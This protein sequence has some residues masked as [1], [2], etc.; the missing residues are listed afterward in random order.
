MGMAA[1]AASAIWH[2]LNCHVARIETGQ[3]GAVAVSGTADIVRALGG[4]RLVPA[5]SPGQLRALVRAGLPYAALS[6]VITGFR[7]GAAE[8]GTALRIPER[9]LARRRK[10]KRLS[11]EES[12]RLVRLARIAAL[13]EETLGGRDRAA[14]WLTAENRALGGRTPI[15][16]LDTDLGAEEVEA[17]L[18]RL[19]HGIVG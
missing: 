2:N 12:D 8:T 18:Q 1:A 19:A 13:A 16:E 7:L 10:E 5:R 3:T 6:A 14:R 9:T 17:A 11:A 15:S 4:T